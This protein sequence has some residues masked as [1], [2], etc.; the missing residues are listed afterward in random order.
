M[1]HSSTDQKQSKKPTNKPRYEMPR[2]EKHNALQIVKGS[3]GG[4]FS[5]LYTE[6]S[7]YYYY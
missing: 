1:K 6:C 7:L 3:G 4:S 2:T 5:G